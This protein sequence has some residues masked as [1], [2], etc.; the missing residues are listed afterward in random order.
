MSAPL[1]IIHDLWVCSECIMAIANGEH[2]S[3]EHDARFRAG[4]ERE[5]PYHW[6]PEGP[7]TGKHAPTCGACEDGTDDYEDDGKC[8]KCGGTG[9]IDE[10]ECADVRDFSWSECDCC[11]SRLGGSRHRC[12]L[13]LPGG[14]S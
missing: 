9:R 4:C 11:E 12:A 6:V 14:A 13:T 7:H 2:S 3:P 10:D 5:A 8:R 1:T